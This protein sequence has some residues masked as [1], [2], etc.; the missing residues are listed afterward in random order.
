MKL[1]RN[2]SKQAWAWI[3]FKFAIGIAWPIMTLAQL[4][5][6]VSITVGHWLAI[7]WLSLSVLGASL[8]IAGLIMQAQPGRCAVMGIPVELVGLIFLF[9]GPFL[10][11]LLYLILGI[12]GNGWRLVAIGLCW[13]LSAAMIARMAM[14]IPKYLREAHD[15]TKGG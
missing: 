4:P 14:V 13:G 10:F 5:P 11:C 9:S 12:L 6:T 1:L 15:P 3:H 7:V 2:V 8:A